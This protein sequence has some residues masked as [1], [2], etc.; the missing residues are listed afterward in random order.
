MKLVSG[1]DLLFYNKYFT[2]VF[3]VSDNEE[4]HLKF[5]FI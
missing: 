5:K 3:E 1:F 4:S 2:Y